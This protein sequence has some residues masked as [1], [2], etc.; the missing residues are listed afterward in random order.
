MDISQHDQVKVAT[1]FPNMISD[2]DLEILYKPVDKD[3]LKKIIS[4]LKVDKS[5]GPDGW[6]V[7]FLN[8]S[9][10]WW[11]MI[12]WIW[13]KSLDFWVLFLVL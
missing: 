2:S 5:P 11:E 12:F 9:L 7:E 4:S 3:E 1:L 6:T 8:I 13:L 10:T